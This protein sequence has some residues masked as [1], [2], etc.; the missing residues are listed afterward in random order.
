MDPQT[1]PFN[2]QGS[3]NNTEE[4]VGRTQELRCRQHATVSQ[5]PLHHEDPP[6]ANPRPRLGQALQTHFPDLPFAFALYF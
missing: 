3:G 5:R 1:S 2:P 4:G 6:H